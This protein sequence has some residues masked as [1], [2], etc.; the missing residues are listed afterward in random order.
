MERRKQGPRGEAK[1][2]DVYLK[3]FDL[4]F[5]EFEVSHT[6]DEAEIGCA[7]LAHCN[8]GTDSHTCAGATFTDAAFDAAR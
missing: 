7:F 1:R 4:E 3:H 6:L 8:Y 5:D 2:N